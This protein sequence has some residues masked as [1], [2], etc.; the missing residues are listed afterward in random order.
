MKPKTLTRPIV[1]TLLALCI[2]AGL[3]GGAAA[4]TFEGVWLSVPKRAP[5]AVS[6]G[7]IPRV[8]IISKTGKGLEG[9]FLDG[10]EKYPVANL[11]V[12]DGHLT[13]T[14][15]RA[16]KDGVPLFATRVGNDDLMP[17][18]VGK[19][20]VGDPP[21]LLRRISKDALAAAMAAAP[22]VTVKTKQALPPLQI[23][24]HNGLAPTPPMGWNSWN[25][26][27]E[28]VDDADVRAIADAM[29]TSGLRDAGYVYITIDDGWAGARDAEGNMHPNAK[30][31]DMKAL[32]AYVHSKG[33]RF[34]IYSSP[35]PITCAN[36][37][38]SHGYEEK[39][40]QTYAAWRVD[41]L[42]YDWC[43]A[44]NIYQGQAEMR[45]VYQKM[46]AALRKT[47]R[48]I[49]YSLCQYGL[50][51]VESWGQDA[52]G[53]LWRTGGD[54]IEGDRWTAVSFGF[55]NSLPDKHVGPG[56][57][58]DP[59]MLLVG[60]GGLTQD[61]SRTHITLWAM[62]AAPLI[63]GNDVRHMT[64][65]DKSVLLNRDVIAVDQDRLGIKGFRVAEKDGVQIWKKPLANGSTAIAVFNT[66]AATET[67]DVAWAD[68]GFSGPRI[69]KDLWTG[70]R[71]DGATYKF[72][73]L[74]P[75]HGSM[76][77]S[78]APL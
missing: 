52:G 48:P 4:D 26:F 25:Y 28:S 32:A 6:P 27:R 75:R 37:L 74:V 1:Q 39:D 23:L 64:E 38:G 46:G 30:F 70:E 68:L 73:A 13:L 61:E 59:D 5:Q 49:V 33:L 60:L 47:G 19:K 12:D 18:W 72:H 24:P 2:C 78:V 66:N 55:S 50:F 44:S 56:A 15:L 45:A 31:P 3:T 8:L 17:M 42:K 76:L 41:Y 35:G 65:A 51:D 16:A 10:D 29:V 53:N 62:T 40:A 63:L 77:L 54:S 71:L 9:V 57:W 34:G 14:V 58:N 7:S 11:S 21:L 43:S 22:K 67:A 36:F 20:P 69:V